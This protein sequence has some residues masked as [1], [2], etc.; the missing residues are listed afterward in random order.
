MA[1]PTQPLTPADRFR[2]RDIWRSPRGVDWRVE[3]V[4]GYKVRLRNVAW[5]RYTQWRFEWNTGRLTANPWER[6][7]SGA[8][9][10]GTVQ[11][12][13]EGI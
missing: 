1:D 8:E 12:V 7:Q 4:I 13:Q 6:I 9:L 10:Q 5:P 11:T 3:L 2:L